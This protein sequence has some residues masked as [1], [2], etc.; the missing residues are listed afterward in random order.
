MA[1]MAKTSPAGSETKPNTPAKGQYGSVSATITTAVVNS[2]S[3][4]PGRLRKNGL[5]VRTTSAMTSS[6]RSDSTNQLVRNVATSARNTTS[7]IQ[8][9]RK[10]N[11]ELRS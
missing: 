6:V 3:T 2:S 9:V 4:V 10:S 11:T 7:S 8:N 5:W 1:A